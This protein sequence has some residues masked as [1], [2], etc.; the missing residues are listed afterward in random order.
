MLLDDQIYSIIDE[1]K[2]DP[3]IRGILLTGSYAYGTPT[4]QSDLDIRSI[5]IDPE[6]RGDKERMRFDVRV[7]LYIETIEK[8]HF[9]MQ[10]SIDE[11]HGA[12]LHFWAN[13]KI[14]HDLDG[15]IKSL[16]AEARDLWRKGRPDGQP[17]TVREQKYAKYISS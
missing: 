3:R 1:I 12:C 4:E 2:L 13:G 10:Q 6:Q 7:E 15:T 9:Y 8:V 5:T 11:G 16:Q 17:W 14:V